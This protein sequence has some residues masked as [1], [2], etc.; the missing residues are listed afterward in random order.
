MRTLVLAATLLAATPLCAQD[1]PAPQKRPLD[2]ITGILFLCTPDYQERWTIGACEELTK[3]A[4][5]QAKA[6]KVPFGVIEP[7]QDPD[8]YRKTAAAAG[9]DNKH[10]LI[11]NL[12]YERVKRVEKGWSLGLRGSGTALPL[13]GDPPNLPRRALFSQGAIFDEGV[14]PTETVKTGKTLLTEFFRYYTTPL[15]TPKPAPAAPPKPAGQKPAVPWKIP[16]IN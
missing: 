6:G 13:P 5:A 10:A 14:A 15:P 8:I 1:A 11:T 12:R 7:S 9:F 16:G 4:V 3:E 2:F